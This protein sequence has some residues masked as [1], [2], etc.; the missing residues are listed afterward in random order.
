MIMQQADVKVCPQVIGLFA[1]NVLTLERKKRLD[2]FQR[3]QFFLVFGIGNLS[4]V[5]QLV[6][7]I[8]LF[9]NGIVVFADWR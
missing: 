7:D 9:W 6:K 4:R 8:V 2:G 3:A 5:G 1:V